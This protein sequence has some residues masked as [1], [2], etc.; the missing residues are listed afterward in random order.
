MLTFVGSELKGMSSGPGAH[1]GIIVVDKWQESSLSVE[2]ATSDLS[3]DSCDPLCSGI[4]DCSITY[5]R[6]LA[7]SEG[8]IEIPGHQLVDRQTPEVRSSLGHPIPR[9]RKAWTPNLR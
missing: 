5:R 8:G 7:V 1:T 2:P 3:V 9:S 4:R 6:S